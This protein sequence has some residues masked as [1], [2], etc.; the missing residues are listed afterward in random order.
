MTKR[1]LDIAIIGAGPGGL[2][3]GLYAGRAALR[4][5]CFEKQG[6]GGQIAN[7]DRVE[8]Y[9]GF[10]RIGGFELAERMANHA[11]KFGLEID[12]TEV[13]RISPPDA[14][15]R[16]ALELA[17][18]RTL[19]AGAVIASPGGTP[20]KLGV[21]GED[22]LVNRG[23]SYCAL[24]DGAFFRD[25]V[26]V[27]VGGGDQAVEEGAF[28]T[29]FGSVVH[30]VHRR[31]EFRASKV[32][33]DHAFG[34]AKLRVHRSTV[35]TEILGGDR[36]EGVRLKE[37]A[38]GA[39]SVLAA[40]AVFPLIGFRPNTGMLPPEIEKSEG[41]YVITDSWMRTSVPGIYAVGDVREQL[42]RQVTNAVGD[43]TTAAVAAER[44]I[45]SLSG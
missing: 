44:Y 41:G 45:D 8:D 21:P 9:P 5:V 14:E 4:A 7:T 26:I 10:E 22:R 38:S 12:F 17:D 23:V 43:G 37:M 39:E 34:N 2:T 30:L 36:V 16:I 33:Q 32:A 31:D 40:G 25:Q 24:C 11:R 42:C 19:A 35:V 18:G 3:A 20:R 15:H 29:K 27:V 1:D 13:L 6:I 28:L